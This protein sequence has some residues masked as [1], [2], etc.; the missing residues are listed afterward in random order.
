MTTPWPLLV[1]IPWIVFVVYWA[2]SA[3]KTRRTISR[4]SF[5]LRSG[6]LLSEAVG[7]VLLFSGTAGIG[8]LGQRIFPRTYALS[9]AGIS[10]T[11]IGIALALW[12]R[13]HLGQ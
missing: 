5:T 1:E 3:L 4:E 12:A 11:W 8:V 6:I 10:L 9:L 2:A 7:F 13:W